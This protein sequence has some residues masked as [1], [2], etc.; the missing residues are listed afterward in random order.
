[1]VEMTIM[2]LEPV[3]TCSHRGCLP[4][5]LDKQTRPKKFNFGFKLLKFGRLPLY[6]NNIP[7]TYT[8]GSVQ[9]CRNCQV[10]LFDKIEFLSLEEAVKSWR[11]N[12]NLNFICRILKQTVGLQ[13]ICREDFILNIKGKQLSH[14]FFRFLKIRQY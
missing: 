4:I 7:H 2:K 6:V 1:M 9:C 3:L 13:H 5:R 14:F 10:P 11:Y 12:K 8:A